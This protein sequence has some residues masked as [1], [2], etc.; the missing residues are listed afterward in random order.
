M[1]TIL[2]NRQ[3]AKRHGRKSY[4]GKV[5]PHCGK[6][7]RNVE[8]RQCIACIG[9]K[10]LDRA[11]LLEHANNGDSMA[12]ADLAALRQRESQYKAHRRKLQRQA[13]L[14]SGVAIRPRGRPRKTTILETIINQLGVLN[15][16]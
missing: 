10:R 7:R 2:T 6:A 11:D 16:E 12:L 1:E 4:I 15:H 9:R 13:L 5:C 14:D 8:T 3:S